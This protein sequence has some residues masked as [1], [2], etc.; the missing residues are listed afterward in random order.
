MSVER[1]TLTGSDLARI[2]QGCYRVLAAGYGRPSSERT[3]QVGAGLA[4]LEELGLGVFS[5]A[6]LLRRWDHALAA[7]APDAVA[8]EYVRLFGSGM[9]G[10]LCPA[11]ES[12][13]LGANLAGDPA[14]H[15]GRI[16]DLM[17]RSGFEARSDDH[18]PDHLIVELELASALCAS[19]AS[20]RARGETSRRWLESQQELVVVLAMWVPGFAGTVAERDQSGVFAALTAATVAFV[21]HE[22]DLVRVLLEASGEEPQ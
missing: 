13:H 19:E 17:R 9:D 20:A 11:I 1:G 4:A 6:Q 16:E 5:F 8:T 21:L 15:A 14:R 18:P 12:Q 3:G 10:A 7:A 2:R 22:H